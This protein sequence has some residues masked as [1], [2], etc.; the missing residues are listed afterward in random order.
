MKHAIIMAMLLTLGGCSAQTPT[1]QK[2]G[3]AYGVTSGLFRDRWWNYYERG[4]S[5]AEGRFYE[6]AIQDFQTA[7]Q[8]RPHDQW[9]GRTYGMHFIDYFPHREL[10]VTYYRLM[11][12]QE[13]VQELEESLRTAE[14][15]KSKYYLNKSRQAILEKTGQ[16]KNPPVIEL[17]HPAE[18]TVTNSFSIVVAG[19]I[20]DDTFVAAM[21]INDHP[22]L[23]EL[24]SKKVP[25]EQDVSLKPG[26]NRIKVWASDLTGK[27]T[28]RTV[29]VEVDRQGPMIVLEDAR[30]GDRNV[31]LSGYLSDTTGIRTFKINDREIP[32]TGR[33]ERTTAHRWPREMEFREHL[34]LPGETKSIVLEATDIAGNVTIGHLPT[35]PRHSHSTDSSGH[36]NLQ[37]LPLFA[38]ADLGN[39]P[40]SW[41]MFALLGEGLGSMLDKD[42]PVIQLKGLT[43][44][45]TVYSDSLYIEGHVRDEN[46]LQSLVMNGESILKRK[47]KDVF[48]NHLTRLKQGV[49]TFIFEAV[50][51]LGN[52]ELKAVTV[53]REIPKIRQVGSRMSISILPFERRGERST[54][55]DAIYDSLMTAFVNQERFRIVEREKIEDVLTELKL[56]Q[57]ELVDPGTAS[58]IGGIVVADAILIGTVYETEDAIEVLTR[59]VDTETSEILDAEDVFNE[60]KSLTSVND[61]MQGLAFKHKQRFPLLEGVI[62]KKEG[63]ALLIDLGEKKKIR[64]NMGVI[65][66]QVG[67]EIYHPGTGRVLGSEPRELGEAKVNHVYE[68]FSRALLR[69]G[70]ADE[71]SVSD[72]F[73]TK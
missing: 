56:S 33:N 28:E 1:Y 17:K 47:G 31:Q 15:A 38:L 69:K 52:R 61:L 60:D 12:H 53:T 73:I 59:L 5:F 16:D 10:G 66:F 32:I 48:F 11:R 19:E 6:E 24:S 44:S 41:E 18:R 14:S 64:R 50:D 21:K 46:K 20:S 58:R 68:E 49:N 70:K 45:Q 13:A 8:K 37:G 40:D 26:T 71:I 27:T 62:L 22:T 4:V 7:V 42:P 29:N 65:I 43:E 9:R 57:T 72:S 54:A 25:L 23:L 67:E 36:P 39:G 2:D 63:K 30:T 34:Q 55:G 35:D 3:K 51:S